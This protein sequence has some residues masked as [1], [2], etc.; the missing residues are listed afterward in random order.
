M[1]LGDGNTMEHTVFGA[2]SAELSTLLKKYQIQ[3]WS[4]K[5]TESAVTLVVQIP[6]EYIERKVK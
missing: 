2:F 6:R 3:E 1:N 4:Y 5:Y